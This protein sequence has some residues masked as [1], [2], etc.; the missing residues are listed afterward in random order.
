MTTSLVSV[1]LHLLGVVT[2]IGGLVYQAHVLGPAA[3]RDGAAPLAEM[4]RRA[5]RVT[6]VAIALVVLTGFYNVTLLGPLDRVLQSGAALLLALKFMLVLAAVAVAGQ[7]DFAQVPR[8]ARAVAS[9]GDPRPALS[10]IAWMDRVVLLLAVVI[11]Y[12]GLA[13]SRA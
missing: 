5:R 11:I 10:A 4:L 13:V 12:L 6:W 2:W 7:R 8:L 1:W 3:R 9:G